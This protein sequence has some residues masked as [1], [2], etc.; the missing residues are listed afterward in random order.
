MLKCLLA[1]ALTLAATPLFAQR[2]PADTIS[3]PLGLA[4]GHR[5]DTVYLH[6]VG[7]TTLKRYYEKNIPGIYRSDDTPVQGT[8]ILSFFVDSA[9]KLTGARYEDSTD[10]ELLMEL[11]RVTR[12]L[13]QVALVP[14]KVAGRS[15]ASKVRLKVLFQMGSD[16]PP[17]DLTADVTVNLYGV[18]R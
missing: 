1:P 17:T 16:L 6:A 2:P 8:V 13:S 12:K 11:W 10:P 15:V 3:F 4:D 14:T 5:G 9:G 18:Q 7:S